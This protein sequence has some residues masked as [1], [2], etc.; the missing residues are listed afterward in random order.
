MNARTDGS[1]KLGANHKW[2]FF[3]SA[4]AAWI[5]SNEEFMK[6]QKIFSTLKLRAGYGV[7]GNQDAISPLNSLQVLSPNGISSYNNQ[8]VVTYAVA[9]NANPDLKWETKSELNL[10]LDFSF[11]KNRLSGSIDIYHRETSDL[12]STYEVP[13]PPYIVSSMMANVGKIRNQGIEL[14]LSGTPIKTRDLRFDITGTF[15]YNKNKII[16]LS[17]GLYQKDYWYEGATGSPIQ[18]HTH[19]VREGDPV[20]N[21]HGFQTHSLT[22]DGLWM[23]YGADGIP[24]TYGSLNLALSYKGFDVSV[25]FRGAFNFQVLN[26][27]RMHWETTSRIGEGNLPRSV[28]EKPFG[29]NSYVKG[30]PAMQSYYVEDGDYVKL[31]NISVGYTFNLKK[32][33]VIQRLRLYVAGNNLLTMTGYKGLDPEVS[34]K[35]LAPGVEGSGAGELYPT[36]RQFTVGLNLLF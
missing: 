29:S 12:L 30:A 26:R 1:S 32:Q 18:T 7:T 15:S 2:G 19:I 27:Q 21:F 3:P 14:L 8:S 23:V 4:S 16:S 17:N 11:L 31:D 22:S 6:K 9:S 35:G 33:K 20:G 36:T 24:T 10:G 28:L 13:T 5:I 25:M 34:I